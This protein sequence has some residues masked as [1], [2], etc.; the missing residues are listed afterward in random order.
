MCVFFTSLFV[1]RF[2]SNFPM[3]SLLVSIAVLKS[4]EPRWRVFLRCAIP[5]FYYSFLKHSHTY[6]SFAS[7]PLLYPTRSCL[8]FSCG[9]EVQTD[10]F[11]FFILLY[12]CLCA[13]VKWAF[14]FPSP[15]TSDVHYFCACA[16]L[17]FF[18]L[19]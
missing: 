18:L 7:P 1:F 14:F 9:A 4:Q 8:F 16:L 19:S 6:P 2:E 15:S 17:F 12:E 10:L 3:M 11:L 5:V 13:V